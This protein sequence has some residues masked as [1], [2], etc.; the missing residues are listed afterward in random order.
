MVLGEETAE[1]VRLSWWNRV[2]LPLTG[3]YG[4]VRWPTADQQP[5]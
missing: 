5:V 2:Q 4:F 1:N 3:F